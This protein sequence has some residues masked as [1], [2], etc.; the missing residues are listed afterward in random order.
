MTE[1][2]SK[3]NCV[4]CTATKRALD[5]KGIAYKE[6][7]M[8]QDPAALDRAKELGF[9]QAPV[10]IPPTGAPWSGFDPDKINALALQ[11]VN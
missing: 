5:N 3:D 2:L 4:Q 1:L 8:S 11:G 6:V 7:N 10:V 9:L